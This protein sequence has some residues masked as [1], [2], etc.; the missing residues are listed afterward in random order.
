[1]SY[2]K[3]NRDSISRTGFSLANIFGSRKKAKR[4][5]GIRV[6]KMNAG[7]KR[8]FAMLDSLGDSY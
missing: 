6:L 7:Q 8:Y 4:A 2:S 1:M 3:R 5:Q